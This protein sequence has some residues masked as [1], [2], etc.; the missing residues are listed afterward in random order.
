MVLRVKKRRGFYLKWKVVLLFFFSI[1]AGHVFPQNYIFR[2]F[3]SEDGLPQSYVYS[4]IQD[5]RGYLWVG[6]GDGL[7]RFNGF[8]FENYTTDDS[9]AD[10]FITCGIS[11][12]ER[13][14]FGH[15]NGRVTYFD[16]KKFQP[17]SIPQTVVSPVT[18]LTKSGDG[19]IWASTYS[20]GL[21]EIDGGTAIATHNFGSENVFIVSFE[22]LDNGELLVGTNTGLLYCR[23]KKSGEIEIVEAVSEIPDSKIAGIRKMRNRSGFY[24]ATENDGVFRLSIEEERFKVSELLAEPDFDFTGIQN[25]YEDS[26]SNLWLG[27]FGTGLI[28]MMKSDS[29]ALTE[30]HFYSKTNGFPTNNVKTIFEDREGNIWTGNYGEGLTQI[31]P[32]TFSVYTFDNP[33]YGSN[34]FSIYINP[35]YRWIGTE[36]GLVKMDP[37]TDRIVKFYGKD[38]GLPDDAVTTIYSADGND[39][40]IGTRKNGV[41]RLDAASGKILRFPISDGELE[42]SITIITGKD[43]LVWIGTKKG[44]CSVNSGTNA[45]SWYSIN[46]GGLPH[47]FLNCLYLDG[48]NRLW[49]STNSST[50]AYIQNEKVS[51]LPFNSVGVILPVT[52]DADYRIWAGSNG[53][54]VFLIE[55]DSIFNLTAKEGL[56]SDYCYSLICD[57][58]RN[59]WVGHKGGLSRISTTDFS[60]KPIRYIDGIKDSFQFNPNAIIKDQQG[61]IWFGS[62]R[63]L[64]SYD[65]S[66]ENPQLEPPVLGFTSIKIN[67]EE[68]EY[69][70]EIVLSPGVYKI[71]IDYLGINLKEPALVN[72][73]SKLEGYDEWSEITKSTY[74]TYPRLTAGNYKFILKANN[75]DGTV[76]ESPLTMRIIIR[77]PVWGK[78]WFYP[79]IVLFLAILTIS[80]IK[81]REYNFV[82]EK[83]V[84]EKKVQERT[85]EIQSQ[86]NELE[87]QRDMIDEKNESITSSIKYASRI[88]NAVFPPLELIDRLLPDNF[89][90]SRP[91]DIVSGDFYWLAEKD[92]KIVIVL[93]DCTGHGVPGAFMSLLGI[94]LLNE[95]V[96]IQGITQSD[97]IVTRLRERVILSLQQG[98]KDVPTSDGLDISLCV[99]DTKRRVF[100]FTGGMHNIVLIR[101]KQLEEIKADR[102]SVCILGSTEGSFTMKEFEFKEGDILYMFSDG[103]QDQFGGNF[104]KKFLRTH[105]YMAL[106]EVHELPMN[107]QKELLERKLTDW[108]KDEIQTD[109][110]TV[111]GIRF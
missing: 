29:G 34:I 73:Q 18:H 51:K 79:L 11:D 36:K 2:N 61:R 105:F 111:M 19:Q 17:I 58:N 97:A 98:R 99:L 23:I 43:E 100:Q 13:L 71:R 48:T 12:G 54:G 60:V 44:L 89:I 15:M 63:G 69:T 66:L 92:N 103:Y 9:L 47:N 83:K 7:S 8:V 59:I 95:I 14:W 10:N 30:A 86:K 45:I 4:L 1:L 102:F 87:L 53:H 24:V 28:K 101:N 6:T 74:V 38:S 106:L 49:V 3:S 78:W 62:D 68:I 67:D 25:I 57:D 109:D 31:T 107:K 37:L 93:A 26:Q 88:Q 16:G 81:W 96:N 90:L 50:L 65:P 20:G 39:L 84:L 35:E 5:E 41:F 75:G 91:K 76:T 56:L 46:Q 64:V 55:S 42:N 32:K 80:Y 104:D 82:A 85:Y 72:Y 21:V 27:S 40:W 22:F 110:I 52:E 70:D 33:L 94:T 77:V 108:M